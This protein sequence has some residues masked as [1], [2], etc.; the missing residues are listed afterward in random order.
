MASSLPAIEHGN[1]YQK[2]VFWNYALQ[3][4]TE[5]SEIECIRYED[6]EFKSFDD[7]VVVY[8]KPQ[9]FHDGSVSADYFQIKYHERGTKTITLVLI[10][11]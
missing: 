11:K 10:V 9:V 6:D 5:G 4:L 7:I 8:K 2:L 1:D 3:L